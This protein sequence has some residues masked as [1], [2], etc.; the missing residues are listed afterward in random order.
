MID[1]KVE[2]IG[3]EQA[4]LLLE[5]NTANF[6]RPCPSRVE[7]YAKEMLAG[8]WELNGDTIKI[9]GS[10]L[11]DGQHRLLAVV[12]SKVVI[13]TL[14]VRGVVADGKTIDRGRPRTISQWFS[15][16]GIKNAKQISSTARLCVVYEKGMWAKPTIQS[17][18]VIDSEVFKFVDQ[19]NDSLQL[20][21][22]MSSNMKLVPVSVLATLLFFGC[23]G[24]P[25][26]SDIAVWFCNGLKTG[27]MLSE[28]DA[29]FHLRNRL[30]GQT[31]Q[32]KI[33]PFMKRA[34]ITLAWNKTVDGEACSVQKL[35]LRLTGPA[36]QKAPTEIRRV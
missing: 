35:R 21:V 27:A 11:L 36:K 15:H 14:V 8:N 16:M 34:L 3:P 4:K 29:V 17:N 1:A 5:M 25:A 18:D 6:R 30:L 2:T 9:N 7:T 32:S 12:K 23:G 33:S 28:D 13:Q 31:M 26:N 24:N 20:C 22:R 19:N 10:V